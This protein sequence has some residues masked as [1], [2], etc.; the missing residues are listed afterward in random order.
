MA[1]LVGTKQHAVV[2]VVPDGDCILTVG[3]EKVKMRVNSLFLKAA[4]EPF[5][6]MLGPGWK[7]GNKL[8][9]GADA[10]E[11]PLPDDDAT[12]IQLLCAVVH[13][14]NGSDTIPRQ[15]AVRTILN[16]AMAADKYDC[17]RALKFASES[18]LQPSWDRVDD[19]MVLAAAAYLLE[20]AE[21]FWEITKKM[22]LN[23]DGSFTTLNCAEV[24]D[25][26][27]WKVFC[28]CNWK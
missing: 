22:I 2:E 25:V 24:E 15:L 14:Q 17:V 26:M 9:D 27:D 5:R 7:E 23:H 18:W 3:P 12:A 19:L 10:V 13:H 16:I 1:D 28:K 20:N 21:A 4:S 11:I 6:A 8:R